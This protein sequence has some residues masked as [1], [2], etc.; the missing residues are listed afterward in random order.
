MRRSKSHNG[1][2]LHGRTVYVPRMTYG[3][4]RAFVAALRSVGIDAKLS[5]ASDED[6]LLIGL[7]YTSGDECLPER[8]TLGNF[9][10]VV[11]APGFDP[12]K[13]AFFM[14]TAGGPCRFGQYAPYARHLLSQLGYDDVMIFS[15]TSENSYDGVGEHAQELMRTAWRAL[16][17]SDILRKMLLRTRP[18][19]RRTGDSDQVYEDSLN[20]LCAIVERQQ[21]GRRRRLRLMQECLMRARHSFRSVPA[22]YREPRPLIG[23]VG[24]IFCRLNRFSNQETIRAIERHGGEA[25]ISDMA[26]WVYYT[27]AG[28]RRRLVREGKKRSLAM[29]GLAVKELVQKRDE[30]ALY[31][32]FHDDFIGYEEP[33]TIEDVLRH[34][35][36][37]LPSEGAL[38]EMVLSVGKAV[39]LYHKG[40]D[41]IADISPFTC[42]NGIVSEAIFPRVSRE[43]HDI[44]IRTFYFDGKP[45]AL[46]RD[47]GIFMELVRTYQKRK[48]RSRRLPQCFG[49]T[50]DGSATGNGS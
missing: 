5:P 17:A 34:S 30:H 36:P 45:A 38:G 26:E 23:I 25:W 43:H 4:A 19:E 47:V 40:A 41:G 48:R 1:G 3:G 14:P 16:V 27:N 11:Q 20:D 44:P 13:T 10:K 15:P 8:V 6:T 46:D 18:Y 31:R 33:Q 2:P 12:A 24:E 29:V 7:A 22:D 39:Y 50:T 32:H 49:R 28:H 35:E 21:V 42:M 9:L 37:Y